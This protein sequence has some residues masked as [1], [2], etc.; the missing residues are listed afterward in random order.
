MRKLLL[1][2]SLVSLAV[3]ALDAG[4][5]SAGL[6]VCVKPVNGAIRAVPVCD[7]NE[8]AHEL[9][10]TSEVQALEARVQTLE[11]LL[12]NVSRAGDTLLFTGL[13]LQVVN[14]TG[15]T[16]G[17]VNGLGNV[18]IGY[19]EDNGDNKTGSHNLVIGANHS[20]TS[21]SGLVSGLDN[22]IGG[23]FASVAGGLR[24]T[25]GIRSFVGGGNDNTAARDSF[26]G[27]GRG[28]TATAAFSAVVGGSANTANGS[29]NAFVGGGNG[30]TATG[31][32]A[33]VGGGSLNVASGSRSFVGGGSNDTAG[34]GTCAWL[35][36]VNLVPC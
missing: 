4:A 7:A 15:L 24:N 17:D 16:D 6:N 10:T 32:S 18:I 31:F 22:T 29:F 11:T 9:A 19:N 27:G 20:Y 21:S 36:E 34:P 25:A 5:A 28:N 3:A 2:V 30:N 26:V 12:D 33:F 35:A 14:G 13:N 8:T 1:I 23:P